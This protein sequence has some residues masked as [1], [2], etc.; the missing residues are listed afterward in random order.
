MI[1]STLS[2]TPGA[3]IAYAIGAGGAA[4]TP[5]SNDSAGAGASGKIIVEYWA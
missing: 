3:T 1:A 4:G 5:S 2:A